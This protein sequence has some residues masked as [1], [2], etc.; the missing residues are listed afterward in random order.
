MS[1]KLQKTVSKNLFSSIEIENASLTLFERKFRFFYIKNLRRYLYFRRDAIVHFCVVR[2]IIQHV[3]LQLAGNRLQPF[4]ER[5]NAFLIL[6]QAILV[7][8]CYFLLLL[9]IVS[10]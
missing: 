8:F 5:E 7:Y 3:V 2:R 4:S 10:Q 9:E 1:S 6:I